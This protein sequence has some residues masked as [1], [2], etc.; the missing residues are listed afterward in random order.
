MRI[1]AVD[2]DTGTLN[3]LRAYLASAGHEVITAAD[4]YEALDMIEAS[5]QETQPIDVM[6]TDLKMP[7]MSGLEL[8]RKART[9]RHWLP[10]VLMTAYGDESAQSQVKQLRSCGYLE[11][12]FN[13]ENLLAK[14]DDA[15]KRK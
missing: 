8:I 5:I 12:P 15:T 13:P 2:D 3:A 14:I 11:K 7:R 1:L 4:G 6:V 10:A 9:E